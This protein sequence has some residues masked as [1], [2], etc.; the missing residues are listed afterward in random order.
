MCYYLDRM[1]EILMLEGE[2]ENALLVKGLLVTPPKM[3]FCNKIFV[4]YR[5]TVPFETL[6]R[7]AGNYR[8]RCS[9]YI[10]LSVHNVKSIAPITNSKTC[11]LRKSYKL[12]QS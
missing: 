4:A 3:M 1:K 6:C 11:S 12:N 5:V 10:N 8:F 7:I 2:N 9:T